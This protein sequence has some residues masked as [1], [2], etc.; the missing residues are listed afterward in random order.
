MFRHVLFSGMF[1]HL[2][3]R[4]VYSVGLFNCVM[5]RHVVFSG[6]FNYL[7]LRLEQRWA[8]LTWKQ[9]QALACF[10]SACLRLSCFLSSNELVVLSFH[11]PYFTHQF[12]THHLSYTI[13]SHALFH[14][15]LS[16]THHL[17]HTTLSNTHTHCCIVSLGRDLANGDV[18]V[19]LMVPG[20]DDPEFSTY[21]CRLSNCSRPLTLRGALLRTPKRIKALHVLII[22]TSTL[23]ALSFYPLDSWNSLRKKLVQQLN[24]R[25]WESRQVRDSSVPESYPLQSSVASLATDWWME[26]WPPAMIEICTNEPMA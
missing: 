20:S 10:F 19:A 11:T 5:F 17:S 4:H 18:L 1:N 24:N 14:K 26:P 2:L 15:Q 8:A 7:L 9:R 6:M 22:A 21:H 3:L 25:E 23:S 12:V 16:H 13:L